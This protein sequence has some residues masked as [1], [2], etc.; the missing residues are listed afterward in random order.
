MSHH[1]PT[2]GSHPL[3]ILFAAFFVIPTSALA[4]TPATIDFPGARDTFAYGINPKG[5]VVGSYDDAGSNTHGFLL[6]GGTFTGIDFPGASFTVA[7]GI[8]PQGDVVGY[9][10]PIG[11]RCLIDAHG[12]V[13]HQGIFTAI[14]FP[15]AARTQAFGINEQGDIVGFYDLPGDVCSPFPPPRPFHG[16]VLH[17]GTFTT[18]DFPSAFLTE[19]LVLLCYKRTIWC[20][21]VLWAKTSRQA[22]RSDALRHISRAWLKPQG[23]LT[24]TFR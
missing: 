18:I 9:Y 22:H 6:H 3:R 24:G 19:A 2:C 14:D 12:F 17:Q 10:I 16:F 13:L 4:F 23:M 21:I 1:R 5:D 8:S 20:R 11:G 7:F 15:G